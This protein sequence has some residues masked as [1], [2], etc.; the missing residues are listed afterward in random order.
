MCTN[1]IQHLP[2]INAYA[3]F[4][5]IP[6][7]CFQEIEDIWRQRNMGHN[8]VINL[9]KLTRNNPNLD[10]FNINAYPKFSQIPS[11]R[12]IDIEGNEI[13]KI[14]RP[15]LHYNRSCQYQFICKIWSIS[16]NPFSKYWAELNC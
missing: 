11:I 12:F 9:R 13:P 2:N 8:S 7:F 16:I 6:S 15:Y 3:K 14:L 1:S 4:C 5:Q 10:L